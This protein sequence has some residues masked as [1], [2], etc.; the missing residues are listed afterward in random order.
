MSL[1]PQEEHSTTRLR[2]VLH[3]NRQ[4]GKGE[5]FMQCA[6]HILQ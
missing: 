3:G 6:P 1:N 4:S 5:K 2:E